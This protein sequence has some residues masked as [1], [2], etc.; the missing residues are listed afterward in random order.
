MVAI[1]VCCL[2]VASVA[3]AETV[4]VKSN[5]VESSKHVQITV[6]L[7]GKPVKGVEVDFYN[8]PAM[9]PFS[10][11]TDENGVVTPSMLAL[12]HQDV[13]AVLDENVNTVLSL[14]VIDGSKVTKLNMDLSERVERIEK[15]PVRDRVQAFQGTVVDPSGAVILGATIQIRR[16]GAWDKTAVIRLKVDAT[17]HFSTQLTDGSYF[18]FFHAQG[19]RT[20]IVPFEVTKTGSGDIQVVL[21]VGHTLSRSVTDNWPLTI[22]N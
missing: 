9:S 18:G 15:L 8:G 17:G 1:R 14:N 6:V 19:F 5:P 2:L 11:L 7:S 22:D 12:G 3:S 4:V 16:K 13:V 20:E 21:Q 10:A